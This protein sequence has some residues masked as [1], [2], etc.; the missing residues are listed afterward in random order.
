[1]H[2]KVQKDFTLIMKIYIYIK[3]KNFH[4]E[5]AKVYLNST[6]PTVFSKTF[7]ATPH[8]TCSHFH[9]NGPGSPANYKIRI[10]ARKIQ[11]QTKVYNPC[12]CEH[13]KTEKFSTQLSS[14]LFIPRLLPPPLG[15]GEFQH[16]FLAG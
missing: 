13:I 12:Y 11:F 15:V 3:R 2:E 9:V 6:S 1:M 4:P 14:A 16:L 8:K 5:D 10:P 7:T